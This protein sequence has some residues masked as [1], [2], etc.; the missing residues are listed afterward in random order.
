MMYQ[1]YDAI[2][3]QRIY[4]SMGVWVWLNML[5]HYM[6]RKIWKVGTKKLRETQVS[7]FS[8]CVKQREVLIGDLSTY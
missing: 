4:I 8:I 1:K 5:V 6:Q 3:L 7:I 2:F